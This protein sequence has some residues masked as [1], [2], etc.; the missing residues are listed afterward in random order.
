MRAEFPT[1]PMCFDWLPD[2]Q[3][4]IVSAREGRLVRR[5]PDGSL[6]THAD[7]RPLCPA[8]SAGTRSSSTVAATSTSTT[9]A[10]TSPAASSRP[11]LIAA[12]RADGSLRAGR[13]WRRLPQRDGGHPGRL[14]PDLRRVLRQAADRRSTSRPTAAYPTS[15]CGPTSATAS[16][17]ASVS[18]PRA[19]SGTATSPTSAASAS[20]RAARCWRRSKLDRG[21]FACALGGPGP[22]DALH[23]RHSVERDGQHGRR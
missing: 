8:G 21:C 12:A 2:G 15:G 7:L 1:F 22:T 19:R 3:L 10:S 9:S 23:G 14:D 16:P 5:E 20:P 13:R 4:V 6:V 17:T 18:T 11:G